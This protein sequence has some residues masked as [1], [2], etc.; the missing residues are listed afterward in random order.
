MMLRCTWCSFPFLFGQ[1]AMPARLSDQYCGEECLQ[2]ICFVRIAAPDAGVYGFCRDALQTP[3]LSGKR[4]DHILR[5]V[6][7]DADDIHAPFPVGN[8]HPS[9]DMTAVFMKQM[10]QL[11]GRFG[12]F[13]NDSKKCD[14]CFHI[15]P[16]S[17]GLIGYR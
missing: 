9:D 8:A 10:I 2:G 17:P 1:P 4:I 6:Y 13:N 3:D 16:F 15:S 12:I 11:P 5:G 7:G 14:S